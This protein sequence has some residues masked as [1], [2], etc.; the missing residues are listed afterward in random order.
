MAK[1]KTAAQRLEEKAV[2]WAMLQEINRR[3]AAA[4]AAGKPFVINEDGSM[5]GGVE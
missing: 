1:R 2:A 5:S 3:V 4:Q